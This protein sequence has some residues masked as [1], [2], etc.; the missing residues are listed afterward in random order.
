MSLFKTQN[1]VFIRCWRIQQFFAV[2]ARYLTAAIENEPF[3]SIHSSKKYYWGK[4]QKKPI[5]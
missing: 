3:Y 1:T 5:L 2:D 4:P